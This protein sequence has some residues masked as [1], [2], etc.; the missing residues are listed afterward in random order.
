[1]VITVRSSLVTLFIDLDENATGDRELDEARERGLAMT[2][3]RTSEVTATG[4]R[5]LSRA[6]L[7]FALD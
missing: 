7:D 2:L 5:V 3:G 1:M 4:A 6:T